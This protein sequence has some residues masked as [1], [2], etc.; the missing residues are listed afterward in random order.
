MKIR[1]PPA[2]FLAAG[3]GLALGAVLTYGTAAGLQKETSFTHFMLRTDFPAF[4]TGAR[5]L[6]AGQGASLYDTQAQMPVQA[7]LL[8]PDAYPG[9]L[10][11]YDHLPF[12][13][14]ALAPLAGLP[15]PVSYAAWLG[16]TALVLLLALLLLA[17]EVRSLARTPTE[18]RWAPVALF[19]LS[20]GFVPLFQSLLQAQTAPWDLLSYTLM[21]RYLRRERPVA[22][23][24]ALC[25]VL[26][27]P[28]LLLVPLCLLLYESRWKTL[29]A[30]AGVGSGLCLLITPL[31]GGPG[32]VVAYLKLL[33]SVAAVDPTAS[34]IKPGL[35]E[36]LRGFF[37]LLLSRLAP[38]SSGWVVPL[39]LAASLGVLALVVVAWRGRRSVS[40][41]ADPAGW[42][43]RWAVALIAT[44][45]INPHGM[46][47]ELT[48]LIL[49]GVLLWR[50]AR[51]ADLPGL[52]GRTGAL[53]AGGYIACTVT[54]ALVNGTAWPF[55]TAV[56]FLMLAL[57]LLCI[58]RWW[59][60][61]S[62]DLRPAPTAPLTAEC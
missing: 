45:L 20:L 22:A 28:Q 43:A 3:G 24:L 21:L 46:P 55:H 11:P 59:A 5:L 35:M 48:L 2:H 33:G 40:W 60:T 32:W 50:A 41:S 25:L 7:Q 62:A 47:Y 19:A 1:L 34:P 14:A 54:T 30:F 6:A 4:I 13:A 18:R 52:A 61:G 10:L 16:A 44:L 51:E 39:T 8:A 29:A 23:G 17:G 57:P 36:N 37:T 42:D 53:I 9:G 12:L 15:L 49:P 38:A 27:K 56:L 26:L 58:P 31:L